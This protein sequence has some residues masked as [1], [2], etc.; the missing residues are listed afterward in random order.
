MQ[1]NRIDKTERLLQRLEKKLKPI[2]FIGRIPV[3]ISLVRY[4]FKREYD[5]IPIG[6][7]IA[8]I[9]A[10]IYFIVPI[11]F[12][13]EGLLLFGLVDDAAVLAGCMK[14]IESDVKEYQEWRKDNHLLIEP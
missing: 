9:G 3:I 7:I 10:I 1:E 13:P 6:M 12:I 14:L 4:Y 8:I 5:D 11:D 2:P